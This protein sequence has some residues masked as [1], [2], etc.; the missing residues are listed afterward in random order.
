[1]KNKFQ[2]ISLL[3]VLVLSVALVGSSFAQ[4]AEVNGSYIIGFETASFEGSEEAMTLT[5]TGVDSYIPWLLTVPYF[6][7]GRTDAATF[8]L[9]WANVTDQLQG[10]A[11]LELETVIYTLQLQ[12]PTYDT[13]SGQLVLTGTIT[14]TLPLGEEAADS[15]KGGKGG[16]GGARLP[17]DLEAGTLFVQFDAGFE[18]LLAEGASALD[19]VA[20]VG[21]G[22]ADEEKA[23]PGRA[24]GG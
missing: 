7:A 2:I 20:R 5:L 24:G 3:V 10:V 23:R 13:T 11:V 8:A 22:G 6:D 4:D 16:K 9:S 15:G 21:R 18:A 12:A 19:G 1:M 17:T 14:D